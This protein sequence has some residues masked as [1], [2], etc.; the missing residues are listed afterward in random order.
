MIL[1][2]F[3]ALQLLLFATCDDEFVPFIKTVNFPTGGQAFVLIDAVATKI[4]GGDDFWTAVENKLWEPTTFTTFKAAITPDTTVIDFGSWIGPTV[5]FSANLARKVIAL[6]PDHIAFH[7]LSRN[8]ELNTRL[9]SKITHMRRC[10]S[11]QKEL[12]HMKAGPMGQGDS[13]SVVDRTNT[14]RDVPCDTMM[15]LIQ[16]KKVVAPI[17]IKVDTE[18]FEAEIIPTWKSWIPDIKP[19]IFI[20]MH[21]HLRKYS[22]EEKMGVITTISAFPYVY[23]IT[24]C[25]SCIGN[26]TLVS[27]NITTLCEMC[28]YLCTY[29][30]MK[31]S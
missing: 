13:M 6:E 17:F 19:T 28:D 29:S 1:S 5:L 12:V 9:S 27:N 23:I 11:F 31:F 2:F 20:S 25:L 4:H 24:N 26:F 7:V 16:D 3:L 10:I 21:Q 15:K 8:I 22:E 30:A 14:T 18:G